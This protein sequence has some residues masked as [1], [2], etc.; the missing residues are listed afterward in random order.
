MGT[1]KI[2]PSLEHR[3][4]PGQKRACETLEQ[5]LGTKYFG[6]NMAENKSCF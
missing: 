3:M 6:L 4:E 2:L 5:G 1:V